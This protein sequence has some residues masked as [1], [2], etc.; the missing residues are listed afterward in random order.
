MFLFDV[1]PKGTWLLTRNDDVRSA[2]V[3]LPGQ[4]EERELS[5]LGSVSG[6]SGGLSADGRTLL[7]TDE[8]ESAGST[9]AVS[10]RG[11]DGTPPIRLGPG[12][13]VAFSPDHTR[14]LADRVT[15]AGSMVYPVGAGEAIQV[16][17]GGLTA[18]SPR[19]WFK[20]GRILVCGR[21]QSKPWR[22]YQQDVASGAATPLTP[23][24][25]DVG[26]LSNDER[27][28]VLLPANQPPQLFDLQTQ[29][30][31]PLPSAESND[32]II[33]WSSD[34][35]MLYVQK[36]ADTVGRL[37]RIEVATGRRTLIRELKPPDRSTLMRLFVTSVIDDGA[38][39]SYTYWKR[40]S[41]LLVARGVP[42]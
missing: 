1:S 34:D 21:E 19:A 30:V 24:N 36:R 9:Y 11:T 22:C 41:R 4:T 17:N 5:W 16:P 18:A 39:Y 38:G 35:R 26:P 42:Q 23:D 37:E 12:V 10:V 3:L 40:P 15:P 27:T 2:R 32:N 6:V 29:V 31:R 14:V 7:F 8:S 20:D 13:A 25:H 28:I 33:D